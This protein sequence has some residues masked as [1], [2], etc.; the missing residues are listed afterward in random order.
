MVLPIPPLLCEAK[1]S[2]KHP[3]RAPA[4][5]VITVTTSPKIRGGSG[6]LQHYLSEDNPAWELRA[7]FHS[8]KDLKLGEGL[9]RWPGSQPVFTVEQFTWWRAF[10]GWL[11]LKKWSPS[12]RL[13]VT[14]DR[15][16]KSKWVSITTYDYRDL[17][18][19]HLSD[20]RPQSSQSGRT[21]PQ[22]TLLRRW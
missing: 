1:L 20:P 3:G 4:S 8:C 22:I 19:Q 21:H 7:P 6:F 5:A 17:I 11:P 2:T 9:W 16:S 18:S 15:S 13:S 10:P 12:S 14:S